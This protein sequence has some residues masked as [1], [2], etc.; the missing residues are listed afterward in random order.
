MNTNKPD[1]IVFI[2]YND[3]TPFHE[4]AR[5]N[6]TRDHFEA[7]T[8]VINRS[9]DQQD[10]LIAVL[11]TFLRHDTP[12]KLVKIPLTYGPLMFPASVN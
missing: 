11:Y 1:E 8:L 5:F 6:T 4:V 12:C 3:A 7:C 9:K 10:F 2:L